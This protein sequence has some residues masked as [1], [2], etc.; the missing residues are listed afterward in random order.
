M[1]VYA[2]ADGTRYTRYALYRKVLAERLGAWDPALQGKPEND[3]RPFFRDWLI[4]AINTGV[5]TKL[6]VKV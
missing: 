2:T 3:G 5:I 6:E 1:I 4:E